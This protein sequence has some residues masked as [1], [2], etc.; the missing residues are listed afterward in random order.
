MFE[1]IE[2]GWSANRKL[3]SDKTRIGPDK[4]SYR[5]VG[6]AKIPVDD[7]TV[8]RDLAAGIPRSRWCQFWQRGVYR[9]ATQIR[10]LTNT[11][12]EGRCC[13]EHNLDSTLGNRRQID[14]TVKISQYIA[15][16]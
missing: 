11:H 10:I 1:R 14:V 9:P 5:H 13:F 2:Y 15:T 3:S 7:K 16:R 12:Q 8:S 6:I 4:S